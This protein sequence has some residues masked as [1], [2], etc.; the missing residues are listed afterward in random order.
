M[1]KIK[2]LYLS[3]HSI[4]EYDELKLFK[5]LGID[6]F[7][8]GNY[9]DPNKTDD[10]MRPAVGGTTDKKMIEL[11]YKNPKEGMSKEF[12]DQFNVIMCLHTPQWITQNWGLIKDKIVIWRTNG[13]TSPDIELMLKPYREQG[14]KIIRYSPMERNVPL[15]IGED[16]MIRLYKDPE[17]FKGWTGEIPRIINITQNFYERRFACNYEIFDQITKPFARKV[18]GPH[19]E[20]LGRIN[21]GFLSYER[22]KNVLK[23][24]RAYFYTGTQPAPYT[25][26][27][28]EA[29]MTGIP[30]I[31]LGSAWG[32]RQGFNSYETYEIPD[33]IENGVEGIHS[34]DP[35]T[36]VNMIDLM[37]KDHGV[38]KYIGENGRKKAIQ[39]FGKEKIKEQWR[40]FF[41]S[42]EV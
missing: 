37:L 4:H 2:M 23:I 8:H 28:I 1:Q 21:G 42:M 16:T 3:C 29:M 7:S 12:L 14:L 19:N 38:A 11:A 15:Y 17:E 32:N 6:V 26:N 39:I 33:L 9:T 20:K 41:A 24:N 35:Q 25:L 36:L 18:Y 22:L 5:E 30:I 40:Q 31:A 27:F 34:D 10:N 13:Q